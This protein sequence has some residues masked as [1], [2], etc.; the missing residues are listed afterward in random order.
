MIIDI[1]TISK[2]Q[3]NL[4]LICAIFYSLFANIFSWWFFEDFRRVFQKI[5]TFNIIP[6]LHY[7]LS[8]CLRKR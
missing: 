3:Q 1:T 8:N 2:E 4:N 6:I 7:N 5:L